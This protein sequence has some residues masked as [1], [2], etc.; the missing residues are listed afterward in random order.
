MSDQTNHTGDPTKAFV[1]TAE[2]ERSLDHAVR[3]IAQLVNDHTVLLFGVMKILKTSPEEIL[4]ML[5]SDDV[6]A[7]DGEKI[8]Q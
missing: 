5:S 7:I 8:V 4:K 3:Q 2:R 1:L 6:I